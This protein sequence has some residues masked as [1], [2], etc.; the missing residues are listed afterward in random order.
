MGALA[1]WNDRR[2]C[3][4]GGRRLANPDPH[5]RQG[6]A[7]PSDDQQPYG[8]ELHLL[9]RQPH[10]PPSRR[11]YKQVCSLNSSYSS[12][13]NFSTAFALVAHSCRMALW[14]MWEAMSL[15]MP[16]EVLHSH[17]RSPTPTAIKA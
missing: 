7:Q 9:A 11:D 12:K 4:A 16:T 1:T 8:V 6:P 3:N 17:S 14:P 2:R 13:L 15:P 5:R 10:R